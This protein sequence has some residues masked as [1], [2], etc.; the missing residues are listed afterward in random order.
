V[1]PFGVRRYKGIAAVYDFPDLGLEGIGGVGFCN[2]EG[3]VVV[4]YEIVYF[5]L[6]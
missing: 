4:L 1:F 3:V 5:G 6:V 2:M